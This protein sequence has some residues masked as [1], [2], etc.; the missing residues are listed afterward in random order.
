MRFNR[1]VCGV[2]VAVLLMSGVALAQGGGGGGGGGRGG[3]GARGGMVGMG[4]GMMM[5]GGDAAFTHLITALGDLNLSPDF[6]LTKEQKENLKAIRDGVRAAGEKWRKDHQDE[7]TK[8]QEEMRAAR[9]GGGGNADL[10]QK[11]RDL[12][13]TYPKSDEAQEQVKAL[14][15]ADQRKALDAKLAELEQTRANRMGGR[16]GRGG[17]G[18][19]GAGGQ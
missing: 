10:M 2:A 7:I 6:T 18:G 9:G 4:R 19:G 17:A 15:T 3:R 1:I 13:Q 11:M 5:G 8:L 14:L 12:Y 16:G